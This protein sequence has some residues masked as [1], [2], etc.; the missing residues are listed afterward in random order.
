VAASIETECPF[1][2]LKINLFESLAE[3]DSCHLL[4]TLRMR[5]FSMFEKSRHEVKV[6]MEVIIG[7]PSGVW[8]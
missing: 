8:I 1:W 6:G 5:L 2:G 7:Q 4:I 3:R